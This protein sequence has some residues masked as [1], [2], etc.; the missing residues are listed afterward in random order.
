MRFVNQQPLFVNSVLKTPFHLLTNRAKFIDHRQ[1]WHG[2]NRHVA[3]V[4]QAVQNQW[5][6]HHSHTSRI[7]VDEPKLVSCHRRLCVTALPQYVGDFLNACHEAMII[8]DDADVIV[9]A[10]AAA[11][12]LVGREQATLAQ[13]PLN[14][15]WLDEWLDE[16]FDDHQTSASSPRRT[17]QLHV[18]VPGDAPI[19]VTVSSSTINTAAGSF[20][21][22]TF[23]RDDDP[24]MQVMDHDLNAL[25][26]ETLRAR[27]AFIAA[28]AHDLRQPLQTLQIIN[29]TLQRKIA[30]TAIQ[31]VLREEQRSIESLSELLNALLSISKLESGR[32]KVEQQEVS[33]G[34]LF[35]D[36][37][38][39]FESQAHAK[40][41]ALMFTTGDA[42][43]VTTDRGL[44][45]DLLQNL[46]TNAIR[47]T[48]HGSVEVQC[49]SNA[50]GGIFIEVIDTGIG[51]AEESL[52][53]IWD[54]FYQVTM[55]HRGGS[56]LGLGI[57]KRIAGLLQIDIRVSS[58]AGR[59]TS[60]TVEIPNAHRIIETTQQPAVA[61]LASSNHSG[62]QIIIV[63]DNDAVRMA[64]STYL[65]LDGYAVHGAG[66]LRE[67][68]DLL[69][70]LEV[71]PSIVI[72]DFRLRGNELGSS[73]I[74]RIREKYGA[75]LPAIVLTG[76]T[77]TVPASLAEEPHTKIMGKPV[78]AR[79]LSATMHELL[80]V[81]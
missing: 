45:F 58:V 14:S 22:N 49:R 25:N 8:T 44:L 32:V 57:V 47:Y 72:S 16:W 36:L 75:A 10:N 73:A 1:H 29:A 42:L 41:L 74:A 27:N 71:P 61:E 4:E 2:G 12:A 46:I 43:S 66:S 51:I 19:R 68:D 17:M 28:T 15:L 54:D 5:C 50:R 56:G 65:E 48:D 20:T 9:Y 62:D 26:E 11:A 60:F 39:Q 23:N 24:D 63:E 3:I 34:R 53:K 69:D 38:A 81:Q 77:S 30:D 31:T 76:D 40:G 55:P 37:Y 70:S 67:V 18:P 7:V 6:V 13:Q 21:C 64:T 33:T 78:D 59:G 52:P 35:D 79:L 80:S